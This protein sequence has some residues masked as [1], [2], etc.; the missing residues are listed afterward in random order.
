MAN[1]KVTVRQPERP[2]LKSDLQF[3]VYRD[4]KKLG[5]MHVSKGNVEWWPYM[6]KRKKYRVGWAKL[7]AFFREYGREINI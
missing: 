5:E 3:I 2:V 7:D 1:H 6:S 4:G